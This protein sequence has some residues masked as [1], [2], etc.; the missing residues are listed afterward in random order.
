MLFFSSSKQIPEQ[1]LKSG[2]GRLIPYPVQ[3]I[4]CS[5]SQ[6]AMRCSLNY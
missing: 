1:Y 6:G 2:D 5:L 3:I 4:V